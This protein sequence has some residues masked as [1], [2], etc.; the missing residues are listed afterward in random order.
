MAASLLTGQPVGDTTLV[1]KRIEAVRLPDM[2]LPRAAHNVFYANGELTVVG[3]HT[4]GFVMTP[5]AEYFS[6]GQWHLMNTVYAHDDGTVVTMEEGS[7]VLL[8]GGHERNLG[9]G[10]SYE[11]ELYYPATHSFEG[12]GCL[13]HKR[14]LAQGVELEDGRALVV[15]NHQGNDAFEVFDGKKSFH[16]VKDVAVWHAA[17]YLFPIAN[18]DVMVFG[19]VWRDGRFQP[20]DTVERLKAEPFRAPVLGEWM[21]FLYDQN[22]HALE[23]FIGDEALGDYAYL[24]AA[25]NDSCEVAFIYVCDTVFSLL[26]IDHPVPTETEWGIIKYDRCAIVD[27][28]AHCAYLVGNDPTGRAYVVAV[29]YNQCP[30]SLTL[31]Y[32]DPLEGFGNTTP[33]LTPDGNLIVTGGIIDDNFAPF[34]SVWLLPVS[35]QE[36]AMAAAMANAS[37]KKSLWWIV[38]GLLLFVVVLWVIRRFAS[39][40]AQ[41][42]NPGDKASGLDCFVVP[43]RNDEDSG[44]PAPQPDLV[45]DELMTRIKLLM[46]EERLYLNPNLKLADVAEALD[47]NRNAVSACINA[48]GSTFIQLVNDYRLQHAKELLLSKPGKKMANVGLESGFANERSFFRVFKDAT[49]MTPKEWIDQQAGSN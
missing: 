47:V 46:E 2:N 35:G 13:D 28:Q 11:A 4:L 32:T 17:P 27:P 16:H 15:G 38:G 23:S 43:P 1:Q 9:I 3:G 22:N 37:S 12:F 21:P 45:D 36:T 8:V 33:V 34:S 44:T 7:R 49:G 14:A 20:C 5:T 24:V 18:D 41:R 31:Y 19:A 25:N 42:S 39:L 30:A 40:R 6:E 48:Q 26:P 10:Q 29:E